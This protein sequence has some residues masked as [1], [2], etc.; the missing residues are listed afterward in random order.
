MII[1]LILIF[2]NLLLYIS[3][4]DIDNKDIKEKI[5]CIKNIFELLK[6]Q[7]NNND[8]NIDIDVENITVDDI[9]SNIDKT[10]YVINCISKIMYSIDK[11]YNNYKNFNGS[12]NYKN[13]DYPDICFKYNNKYFNIDFNILDTCAYIIFYYVHIPIKLN[14]IKCISYKIL[15]DN[16]DNKDKIDVLYCGNINSILKNSI[17]YYQTC[18]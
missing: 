13:K 1:K 4:N 16:L 8:I 7:I 6:K 17:D 9:L 3:D 2:K 11:N 12:N 5:K 10:D 15:L 14:D 18:F